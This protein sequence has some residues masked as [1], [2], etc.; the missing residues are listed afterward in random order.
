M[1]KYFITV[2]ALLSVSVANAQ[3]ETQQ[4]R[5]SSLYQLMINHREQKFADDIQEVFLQMPVSEHFN[6]HDL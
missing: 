2:F 6:D 1:K 5:R 3:T 4:Y